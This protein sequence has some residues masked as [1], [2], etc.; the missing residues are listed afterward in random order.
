MVFVILGLIFVNRSFSTSLK[1]AF[2][3]KN[4]AIPYVV[5]LVPALLSVTLLWPPAA[6]LF[7]FGP[8]HADDIALAVGAGFAALLVIEAMKAVYRRF[9]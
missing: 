4:A 2:L 6:E 5:I 1:S 3:R 9:V 7:S 8:L